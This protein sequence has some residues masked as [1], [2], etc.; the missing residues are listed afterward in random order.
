MC[1]SNFPCM[2]TCTHTYR[3][4][5]VCVMA[6]SLIEGVDLVRLQVQDGGGQTAQELSNERLR[7]SHLH[8]PP[9]NKGAP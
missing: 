8:A 5:C 6:Y 1:M 3:H 4:V 2:C 7:F 9:P